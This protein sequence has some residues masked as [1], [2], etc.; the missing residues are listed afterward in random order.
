M[1]TAEICLEKRLS[2]EFEE[3]YFAVAESLSDVEIINVTS[4]I[5]SWLELSRAEKKKGYLTHTAYVERDELIY[6]LE[7]QESD[8]TF[9][10]S[11]E[12]DLNIGNLDFEF[13]SGLERFK[14][15]GLLT[16]RVIQS[17]YSFKEDSER[18]IDYDGTIQVTIKTIVFPGV[19]DQISLR[20]NDAIYD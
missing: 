15:L 12:I 1:L 4:V 5:E 3:L 2:D 13:C 16:P 17:S 11:N 19:V 8:T 14:N 10:D 9:G 7:H 18:H 6:V 20:I